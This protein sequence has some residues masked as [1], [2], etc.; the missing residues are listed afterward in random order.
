MT[1]T[2]RDAF[3]AERRTGIGGSDVQHI[4]NIEPWG[5]ARMLWYG[6]RGTEPDRG[7]V[8]EVTGA[9]VRGQK[10]EDLVAEEYAERTGREIMA[11]PM[12]RHPLN[13]ELL[14][15]IDRDIAA[16][17]TA[18]APG[19]GIL[20]CKTAAREVFFRIKR[21]G[22]PEGYILQLQYAMLVTGAKWGSFA[23]LWPDGWQILWW[24]LEADA[25]LQE[26]IRVEALK[27][28]VLVQN[29]PAP[30][31]LPPE[32]ARCHRCP[33]SGQCQGAAM[34]EL[35]RAAGAG[36]VVDRTLGPLVRE[37][38]DT[39][40]LLKEA[41]EIH[42]GVK[43]NLKAAM[44][45]RILADVPGVAKVHFKPIMEWS[46]GALEELRPDIAATYKRKWDLTALSKD[47]PE[48]EKQFKR[49]GTSRPLRIYP[50][51]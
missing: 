26:S 11:L 8:S 48:L 44:G 25:K 4:F 29:G 14:V 19:S 9:M 20:E 32:D 3:L 30:D 15:H 51:R 36:A 39:H 28:W 47:H 22:M 27:F 34:E 24:D 5:C 46:T 13:P 41:E 40:E 50:A 38:L 43:E 35:M 16:T 10:L 49:V 45:D 23:L 17:P 7:S 6:K 37:F 2:E 12:V 18:P 42:N 33:L 1:R 21:E 31:R